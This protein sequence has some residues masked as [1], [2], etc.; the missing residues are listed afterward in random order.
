MI[1]PDKDYILVVIQ[2][3]QEIWVFL[4][5]NTT[6]NNLISRLCEI[7]VLFQDSFLFVSEIFGGSFCFNDMS[8]ACFFIHR[9]LY[10]TVLDMNNVLC[11]QHTHFLRNAVSYYNSKN[12]ILMTILK[13]LL[14]YLFFPFLIS[15]PLLSTTISK[16]CNVFYTECE[17]REIIDKNKEGEIENRD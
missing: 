12:L 1:A 15:F 3:P 6:I 14:F 11:N 13:T 10:T 4:I 8:F 5:L 2:N 16:L 9:Q 17:Q 7:F